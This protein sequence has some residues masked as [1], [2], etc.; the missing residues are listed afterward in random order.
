MQVTSGDHHHNHH[1]HDHDDDFDD[2]DDHHLHRRS[3]RDHEHHHDR[4]H[5]NRSD[6]QVSSMFRC[7]AGAA[8]TTIS[9]LQTSEVPSGIMLLLRQSSRQYGFVPLQKTVAKL[10]V[11]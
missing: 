5:V 7:K 4:D 3:E 11:K 10:E 6:R 1:D 9:R 8:Y 2:D